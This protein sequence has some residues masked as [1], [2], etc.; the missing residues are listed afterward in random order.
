MVTKKMKVLSVRQPWAEL[1]VIGAKEYETRTRLTNYRGQLLI[2]AT[3]RFDFSDLELCYQDRHFNKYVPD[4]TKLITGAIIGM[5]DLVDC[6]KVESIYDQLSP[7]E[8]A[9]GNYR[10]GRFA[11]E[12]FN[13]IKFELPFLNIPGQLGLWEIEL[14]GFEPWEIGELPTACTSCGVKTYKLITQWNDRGIEKIDDH[15]AICT[16]CAEKRGYRKEAHH[17]I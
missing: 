14:P 12:V 10:D 3:K 4:P 1:L 11:W 6:H 8:R 13:P 7:Q 2:H 5:V 16:K 15:E 9:F 17:A